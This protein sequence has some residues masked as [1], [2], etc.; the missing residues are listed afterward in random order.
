MQIFVWLL[1]RQTLRDASLQDETVPRSLCGECST[2]KDENENA[3]ETSARCKEDC[4]HLF[5]E[6]P[7][8]WE[9][10]ASQAI[11]LADVSSAEAFWGSLYGGFSSRPV[12]L[13]QF[14]TVL[15][16]IWLHHS[17]V[18]FGV[19]RPVLSRT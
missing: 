3:D 5:F 6:F 14:L 18:I 9:I 2:H 4:S 7:F 8:A 12:E 17:K 15:W 10:C 13:G 19:Q 1:L 16:A 11:S